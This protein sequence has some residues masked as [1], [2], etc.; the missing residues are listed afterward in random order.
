MTQTRIST[1]KGTFVLTAVVL[2]FIAWVGRDELG[3]RLRDSAISSLKHCYQNVQVQLSLG[4]NNNSFAFPEI[5]KGFDYNPNRLFYKYYANV[6]TVKG[7]NILCISVYSR[8]GKRCA[9]LANGKIIEVPSDTPR[10]L[11]LDK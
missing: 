7:T 3:S 2:L 4:T 5:I 10:R 1:I 9:L 8:W 11:G 6:K